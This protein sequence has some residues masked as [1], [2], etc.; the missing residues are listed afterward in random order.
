M[1]A[2]ALVATSCA[3]SPVPDDFRI[4]ISAGAM[5]P[6]WPYSWVRI[7]SA[8][9]GSYRHWSSSLIDKKTLDSLEF[10]I[11]KESVAR[12]WAAVERNRFFKLHSRYSDRRIQ[13]GGFVDIFVVARGDSHAVDDEQVPIR[14]IVSILKTVNDVVPGRATLPARF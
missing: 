1:F 12:L 14:P 8:G 11:S 13:D 10:E 2:L 6:A 7:D 5:H 9:H 4:I 3:P